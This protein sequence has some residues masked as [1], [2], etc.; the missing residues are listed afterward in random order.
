MKKVSPILLMFVLV[1]CDCSCP[2]TWYAFPDNRCIKVV[3][4]D[5]LTLHPDADDV[6]AK[7]AVGTG[8]ARLLIPQS[9]NDFKLLAVGFPWIGPYTLGWKL[10]VDESMP[11]TVTVIRDT[12]GNTVP[13]IPDYPSLSPML[14]GTEQCVYIDDNVVQNGCMN[15]VGYICEMNSC[16]GY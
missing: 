9:N 15:S 10:L 16:G 8:I 11:G 12:E 5:L 6:C 4:S 3:Q 13:V 14:T 7:Y 1:L 2:P